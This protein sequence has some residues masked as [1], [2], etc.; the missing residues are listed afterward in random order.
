MPTLFNVLR[1]SAVSLLLGNVVQQ[2]VVEY[3]SKQVVTRSD[4]LAGDCCTS[5]KLMEDDFV[6]PRSGW[7]GIE[8]TVLTD[9]RTVYSIG[10]FVCFQH[11]SQR[12]PG[13]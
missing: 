4:V 13:S 7:D 8:P 12:L 6:Y 2:R 5:C 3:L 10:F 11:I 9:S 1:L